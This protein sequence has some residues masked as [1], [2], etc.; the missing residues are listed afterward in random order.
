MSFEYKNDHVIFPIRA[1]SGCGNYNFKRIISRGRVGVN[2][3]K[4]TP[5]SSSD[6]AY[7]VVGMNANMVILGVT[8]GAIVIWLCQEIGADREV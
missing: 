3:E 6:K 4:A 7:F 1:G 5:V 2:L 8:M